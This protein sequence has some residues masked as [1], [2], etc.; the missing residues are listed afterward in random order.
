MRTLRNYTTLVLLLCLMGKAQAQ[1][2]HFSQFYETPLFRNPA[3]A[4]IVNGDY[5]VQAVYRSQWN[6]ISNA[7]KTISANAEYKLQV[8]GG[9]NYA[10]LG[11]Q[12]FHDE[13]GSSNLKTTHVLPALNFHKSI[14]NTR[15]LY[16]SAGFMGGVVQR[17]FDRSKITTNN[18][19]DNGTDGENLAT[20]GYRYFDGSAGLSL[21][22]DFG[23]S[24]E[25]S[26][27][28]GAAMHHL[29]KPKNSFYRGAAIE[30]KPKY[31]FS[32]AVKLGMTENTNVVFHGDYTMQDNFQEIIAGLLYSIKFGP[33]YE[34][35][36]VA[37]S[38]G[39]FL[40]LND[41]LIPTVKLDYKGISMGLSYDVNIS[42]L[43]NT[44]YG[45]GGFELSL[46]FVGFTQRDN[47]SL[48]AMHCPR[49]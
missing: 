12:V 44:S 34:M 33:D 41:A 21:N 35:P 36:D 3:L 40:R 13:A 10:T 38:A 31:V 46:T 45:Q 1:D 11:V 29:T 32:G 43:K 42:K 15:N 37:L 20:N 8:G 24:A 19:Y 4:G 7:Y 28:V 48:N 6:S 49:F 22:G 26:F 14:S 5:R 25:N 30:V 2:I 9:E 23:E 18:T 16:L 47:S 17:T 39:G 27:V